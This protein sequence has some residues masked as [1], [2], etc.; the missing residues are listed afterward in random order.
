MELLEGLYKVLKLRRPGSAFLAKREREK[1]EITLHRRYFITVDNFLRT[2]AF[3]KNLNS[4]IKS[5]DKIN[6]NENFDEYLRNCNWNSFAN[7]SIRSITRALVRTIFFFF[8]FVNKH[9]R[10]VFL[11]ISRT[12]RQSNWKC[13]ELKIQNYT[14]HFEKF[15][16]HLSW[17]RKCILENYRYIF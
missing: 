3:E 2:Q 10:F 12:A 7:I 1:K 15:Q 14:L 11:K 5:S 9:N 17:M 8:F 6:F 13:D 16:L 4:K